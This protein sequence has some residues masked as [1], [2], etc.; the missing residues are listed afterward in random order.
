MR[1]AGTVL[2]AAVVA[3]SASAFKG[4]WLPSGSAQA[5]TGEG[6]T[7]VAEAKKKDKAAP[8]K[9]PPKEA[10]TGGSGMPLAERVGIQFDLAWTGHFNGLING[11]FNDRSVAAVKAF[12]K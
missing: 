2:V 12:Q 5:Q 11:E 9:A 4:L 10:V 6:T 7:R 1:L 3:M 8:K